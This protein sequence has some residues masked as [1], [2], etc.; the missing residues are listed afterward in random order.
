MVV[1][2]CAVSILTAPAVYLQK[3]YFAWACVVRA[4]SVGFL[5]PFTKSDFA[6]CDKECA[7]GQNNIL[8]LDD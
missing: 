7:L 4:C 6:P 8:S 2:C 3:S 1:I 5:Y